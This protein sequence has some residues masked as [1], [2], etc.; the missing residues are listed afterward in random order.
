MAR[1]WR[2]PSGGIIIDAWGDLHRGRSDVDQKAAKLLADQANGNLPVPHLRLQ[3]GDLSD[4]GVDSELEAAVADLD[5]AEAIDGA[6]WLAVGGNH[7]FLDT[8][9]DD[10]AGFAAKI[11]QDEFI[12]HDIP[13]SNWRVLGMTQPDDTDKYSAD[14]VTWL[15]TALASCADDGKNALWMQHYPLMNTI[16]VY[17]KLDGTLVSRPATSSSNG[18]IFASTAA[19][20]YH[21]KCAST[22]DDTPIRS[23]LE[24]ADTSVKIVALSG[25]S[26]TPIS[27]SR[28]VLPMTFGGRQIAHINL[29]AIAYVG[30]SSGA[31]TGRIRNLWLALRDDRVDVWARDRGA[32]C[33]VPFAPGV[34]V[35]SVELT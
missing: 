22:S 20:G 30:R 31:F 18:G 27:D 10:R 16:G 23:V 1:D 29:S 14:D 6:P 33:W 3:I 9:A 24:A 32:G 34:M 19:D 2:E 35:R 26:H 5:A 25:H 12:E 13:G 15:E 11:G 17:E 21:L 4:T 8:Y 28:L 7:D